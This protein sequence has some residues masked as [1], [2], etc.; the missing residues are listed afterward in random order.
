MHKKKRRKNTKSTEVWR[1][2]ILT[3]KTKIKI[4]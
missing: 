2:V 3:Q 1:G 4:L